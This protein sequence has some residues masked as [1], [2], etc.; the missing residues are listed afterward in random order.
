M[1]IG[2]HKFDWGI[3]NLRERAVQSKFSYLCAIIVEKTTGRPINFVEPYVILEKAGVKIG[4]I[5]N[6]VLS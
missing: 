2:N 4:I 3:D 1:V 6:S 5:G